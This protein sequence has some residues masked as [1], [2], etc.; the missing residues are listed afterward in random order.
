MACL[1]HFDDVYNGIAELMRSPPDEE[2]SSKRKLYMKHIALPCVWEGSE[3]SQSLKFRL[4]ALY[5]F[6]ASPSAKDCAVSGELVAQ[7]NA[8]VDG[9]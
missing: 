4:H 9:M 5:A 1:I 8:A 2:K 6:F 7:Y 3:S